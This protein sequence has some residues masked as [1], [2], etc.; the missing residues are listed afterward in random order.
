MTNKIKVI[1]LRKNLSPYDSS[2]RVKAFVLSL[3]LRGH[4]AEF[5]FYFQKV[6]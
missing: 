3:Y 1:R 5:A 4:T 6:L 2:D